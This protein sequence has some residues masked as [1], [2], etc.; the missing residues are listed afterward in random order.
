MSL[1]YAT[2]FQNEIRTLELSI[3]NEDETRFIPT[4]ASVYV[5]DLDGEKVEDCTVS[6]GTSGGVN[7]NVI[8]A[9]ITKNTSQIP[10]EYLV[11]WNIVKNTNTFVHRTN[12]LVLEL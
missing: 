2:I 4:S 10:A 12:L 1:T 9:L 3:R 11:Y 6:I 5:T 7:E 8:T